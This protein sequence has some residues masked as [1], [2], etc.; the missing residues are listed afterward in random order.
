MCLLSG[1]SLSINGAFVIE[2]KFCVWK[3]SL[4]YIDDFLKI[5]GSITKDIDQKSLSWI[6]DKV[7]CPVEQSNFAVYWN[8][9]LVPEIFVGVNKEIDKSL[10]ELVAGTVYEFKVSIHQRPNLDSS[11]FHNEIIYNTN[12]RKILPEIKNLGYR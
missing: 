3:V 11:F 6:F 12:L 10:A 1:S 8:H 7:D 9:Q 4:Y 5:S 2:P